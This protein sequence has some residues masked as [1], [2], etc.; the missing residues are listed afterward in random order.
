LAYSIAAI[1]PTYRR[2]EHLV[3]T[4]R[5]LLGQS[6]PP[7]EILVLDQTPA[8]EHR[9]ATLRFLQR[10]AARARIRLAVLSRPGVYRARNR[11]AL[12]SNADVLLYLDDDITPSPHL[13]ANHLRHYDDPA[14]SAV[15]GSVLR[16]E[17]EPPVPV[18]ADFAAR[19]HLE[20]AFS[21][22]GYFRRPLKHVGFMCAGN[23][24]VRRSALLA[25]GGWDEHIINYGDRDLG[26]RLCQAGFRI[27]YDPDARVV[28]HVA[29][30]GGSRVT[31]PRSTLKP[32]QRCVSLHYVAWR[33]LRGWMFVKYGLYRAARF[34]FLLRRH[35]CRPYLWPRELLGF[36]RALAVA[37]RWARMGVLSPFVGGYSDEPP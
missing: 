29:P 31:D 26:I 5:G 19:T 32:W 24:S 20:Q 18:P 1:V 13:A 33:H 34:S 36:V 7:D 35:V 30:S 25:V 21:Y 3:A 37:R 9:P 12:F 11:A 4:I 16:H 14:V 28:H 27:D 10:N 17:N 6:R 8:R 22:S 2:E 15:V 23:F